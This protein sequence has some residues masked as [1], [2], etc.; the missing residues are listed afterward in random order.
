MKPEHILIIA[1]AGVNHNGSIE[2]AKQLIDKAAWAGA[3]MIKFQTFKPE[4][5]VSK[6][7]VMADYQVRNSGYEDD[8]S[9]LTMLR[10]LELTA[11]ANRELQAYC[12]T[13]NIRFFSTAFDL[14]SIEFLATLKLGMWKI[15]SGEVTDLPF[16]RRIGRTKEPVILSTGMC[17]MEDIENAITALVEAGTPRKSITLLHCNTEYPTPFK[18]ANLRVMKTMSGHF[19]LPVGFSDHTEGYEATIAAAALGAKVIEKHFTLDRNLPGPDQ[20]ASLE[21]DELKAMITAIRHV[22]ESLGDIIKHVTPSEAH[23]RTAA[24]KSIVAATRIKKGQTFSEKNLTTKR[25]GYGMSPMCWDQ[26]M[27]QKA[28]KDYEPDDVI[29]EEIKKKKV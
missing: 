26:I 1:E 11:D 8:F 5:L 27:G 2:M 4:S 17:E 19:G 6:Q 9:Q 18:D 7:A 14:D 24:R 3:D 13:R 10:K 21:P 28:S 15:P 23:N 29:V 22:E 12:K 20:K 25:P 16:L